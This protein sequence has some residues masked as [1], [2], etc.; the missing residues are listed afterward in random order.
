MIVMTFSVVS[1]GSV[2]ARLGI[3]LGTPVGFLVG[4][5]VGIGIRRVG[6]GDMDG[7]AETA[8][9]G[10]VEFVS[11]G[12]VSEIVIFGMDGDDVGSSLVKFD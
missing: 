8:A 7:L 4:G 11:D 5:F 10:A 9:V 3:V 12:M 1:G 2:L 6:F